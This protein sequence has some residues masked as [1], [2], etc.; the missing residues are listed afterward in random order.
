MPAFTYT[1]ARHHGDARRATATPA[2]FF[3]L[4]RCCQSWFFFQSRSDRIHHFPVKTGV[5]CSVFTVSAQTGSTIV[6]QARSMQRKAHTSSITGYWSKR[7]VCLCSLSMAA[8]VCFGRAAC[9]CQRCCVLQCSRVVGR[10]MTW[11]SCHDCCCSASMLNV[12]VFVVTLISTTRATS[13]GCC[14]WTVSMVRPLCRATV[15]VRLVLSELLRTRFTLQMLG[16]LSKS[17]KNIV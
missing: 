13:S 17:C 12:C 9:V 10:G 14:A 7:R 6:F 1:S 11:V 3:F 2:T 16:F 8:Y 15:E 5:W 4:I